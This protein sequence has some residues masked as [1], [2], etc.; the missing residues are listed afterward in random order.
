MP[1]LQH[2]ESLRAIDGWET[3]ET[4]L[5]AQLEEIEEHSFVGRAL[6]EENFFGPGLNLETCQLGQAAQWKSIR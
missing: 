1:S 4:D 3:E 6:R 5:A 2:Q